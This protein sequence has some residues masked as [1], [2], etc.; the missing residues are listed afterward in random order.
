MV[1]T[2]GMTE[3]GSGVVY[4]GLALD[5]VELAI[6]TGEP[7]EGARDEILIR[8][9]MLLRCYRDGS[10]PRV[11]GPDG[12]GGWFPT[13]DGGRLLDT[14]ALHVDGRLAEVVVTGGEKVW[15]NVVE[16]IV[17][18]H[19]GVAEVAVWKRP[20]PE[21]GEHVVAWVVVTPGSDAPELED[22]RELVGAELGPWAAPKRSC[23]SKHCPEPLRERY[24]GRS[25]S[26]RCAGWRM[27]ETM[28]ASPGL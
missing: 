23:S 11:A 12:Q 14:G 3:T 9:P 24:S 27:T 5:D 21:W 28:S 16:L 15:P 8:A 25:C 20:D 18:T 10:S 22:V 2:Y 13:G 7:D 1:T 6:G 19:Q 26:S 4:D 17:A